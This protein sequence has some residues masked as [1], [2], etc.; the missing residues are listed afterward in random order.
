[1][2]SEI[3]T[4]A[5]QLLDKTCQIRCPA[6]KAADLQKSA[7]YL[8]K[9]MREINNNNKTLGTEN[10]MIMAAIHAIYDL[11]AQQSQKDLYIES[12]SI[13]VRELQSRLSQ[14]QEKAV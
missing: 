14:L 3:Q 12:L 7:Q 1:M 11:L 5:V 13:H 6:D 2:T 4:L 8:D 10:M 9:K